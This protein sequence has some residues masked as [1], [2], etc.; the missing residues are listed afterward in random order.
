MR[1]SVNKARSYAFTLLPRSSHEVQY[2]FSVPVSSPGFTQSIGFWVES[3]VSALDNVEEVRTCYFVARACGCGPS[4]RAYLREL[5][6]CDRAQVRRTYVERRRPLL[7][8]TAPA[9]SLPGWL[10]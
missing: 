5:R 8:L 7:T 9:P 4:H 2:R 6:A 10:R 3:S 1:N